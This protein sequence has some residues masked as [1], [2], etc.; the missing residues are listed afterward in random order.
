M[1]QNKKG[2]ST[3]Q[4]STA[5]IAT[6]PDVSEASWAAHDFALHVK[7]T[8]VKP[9]SSHVGK[10]YEVRPCKSVRGHVLR[11]PVTGWVFWFPTVM[12]ALNYTRKLAGIHP[13]DCCVYDSEDGV[14]SRPNILESPVGPAR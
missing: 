12:D 3:D 13:A 4:G 1:N 9:H 5:S 2:I 10:A 11:L 7:E 6:D 14:L 8:P